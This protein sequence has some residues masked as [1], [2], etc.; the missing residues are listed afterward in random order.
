MQKVILISL[1]FSAYVLQCAESLEKKQERP[2]RLVRIK[3]IAKKK[4]ALQVT[5]KSILGRLFGQTSEPGAQ[6]ILYS[7]ACIPDGKVAAGYDSGEI[8]IFNISDITAGQQKPIAILQAHKGAVQALIAKKCPTLGAR[9]CC[10]SGGYDGKVKIWDLN[11]QTVSQTLR[12]S[13]GGVRS[14]D[15]ASDNRALV[16]GT[17]VDDALNG[18][19]SGETQ[20]WSTTGRY[21]LLRSLRGLQASHPVD[22][23]K[24]SPKNNFL[25]VV[26]FLA[27]IS[28]YDSKYYKQIYTPSL[29]GP[30]SLVGA[31]DF[32]ADDSALYLAGSGM[33]GKDDYSMQSW[34]ITGQQF[35]PALTFDEHNDVWSMIRLDD[36]SLITS[37]DCKDDT[38]VVRFWSPDGTCIQSQAS[39]DPFVTLSCSL[40]DNNTILAATVTGDIQVIT[41][42]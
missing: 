22:V 35:T 19:M 31:V 32:A 4:Q 17:N 41:R 13:T 27:G 25:A 21:K 30:I 37:E 10:V 18:C 2:T 8:K 33:L 9:S 20:I 26:S 36:G 42:K 7:L 3:Q 28:I 34:S 24:Y 40:E 6:S 1:L 11:A 16:I 39:K 23:V 29:P 38:G 5:Q 12:C 15:L 14:L